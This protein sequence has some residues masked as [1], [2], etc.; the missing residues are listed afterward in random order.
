MTKV[1]LEHVGHETGEAHYKN[2]KNN[3]KFLSVD[4]E[5]TVVELMKDDI[6]STELADILTNMTGNEFK[7]THAANLMSRL[8]RDKMNVLS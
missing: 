3:R 8:K 4:E 5:N 6:S 7:T 1:V 2:S